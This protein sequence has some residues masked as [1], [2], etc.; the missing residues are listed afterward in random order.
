[1][2]NDADELAVHGIDDA[3]GGVGDILIT[4]ALNGGMQAYHGLGINLDDAPAWRVQ[5]D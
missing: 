2:L 3:A 5:Q 1:V 4:L